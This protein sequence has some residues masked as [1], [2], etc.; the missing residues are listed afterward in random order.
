[1]GNNSLDIGVLFE[2]AATPML[3][4]ENNS[5]I[6]HVNKEFERLS[7]YRKNEIEN[8]LTWMDFVDQE[9]IERM[10]KYHE[11]RRKRNLKIPDNYEFKFKPRN[12]KNIDM[13][14]KV[15]FLP[16]TKQS[17]V[18]LI[19][20]S[21][22]KLARMKTNH[23][24]RMYDD[25]ITDSI[26]GI[27]STTFDGE[28]N[29][30]NS[31]ALRLFGYEEEEIYGMNVTELYSDKEDRRI[32]VEKMMDKGSIKDFEVR[33]KKKDGSLI[34]C[35][36]TANIH[37]NTIDGNIWFQGFIRDVTE[38]KQL[39][40]KLRES[41][42]R[43]RTIF[44]NSIFGIYRTTPDGKI[45]DANPALVEMLGFDS[46]EEL[47]QRDINIEGFI[48]PKDRYEFLKIIE[49]ENEIMGS[50]S[51]WV[52]KNGAHIQVR[53][54]AIKVCNNNGETLY[55]DGIVEDI[56]KEI[57]NERI[58]LRRKALYEGLF[59]G[60]LEGIIL[61]DMNGIVTQV[62]NE[63][64]KM[65][66]YSRNELVGVPI[67]EKISSESYRG[68][69]RLLTD[70]VFK[71]ESLQLE[72]IRRRKDG[73]EISVSIISS[74]ILLD[75]EMIG[76]FGIYRDISQRVRN[77]ERIRELNDTLKDINKIL[78]H[79]IKN[80][81]M[82]IM[83]SSDIAIQ[84]NNTKS[85]DIIKKTAERCNNLIERMKEYESVVS[86]DLDCTKYSVRE[87]IEQVMKGMKIE[88]KISSELDF[89]VDSEFF[90]VIQNLVM[91]S[92][93]HGN[94]DRIE[95]FLEDTHNSYII[96]VKDFGIGIPKKI[97]A[98]IFEQNFSYGK[99]KGTGI[100]LAIV[101]RIV[102]RHNGM[103]SL[104]DSND[105]ATFRISLPS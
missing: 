98:N 31:A 51:T 76:A 1:M 89:D 25:L 99:T 75:N 71:G 55:Y 94:T 16:E 70:S 56:S 9:D 68:E 103:V 90:S 4:V 87:I 96:E 28:I 104:V 41:E 85:I 105:G 59:E 39:E 95:F 83:Q 79:D 88:Y 30:M 35:I 44:E 7:G 38:K 78:R 27:Y 50:R 20:I 23:T 22:I 72:T 10:T 29:H 80:N 21:E 32:F 92:I 67:D 57:E 42:E 17:L 11:G 40:L 73:R 102:E 97:K 62:N 14:I 8:K 12:G 52:R 19:D 69:S 48:D 54:Y 53:E 33:L 64:L 61:V 93:R 26:D 49:I 3:L 74:P 63:F 36:I 77:E 6:S 5:M 100:G 15:T 46:K 84:M 2:A 45:L 81:L 47:C 43:Y 34:D 60:A 58:S 13:F 65:F 101:K 86:D 82:I 37:H 24:Q 18:S 91:N 66:G